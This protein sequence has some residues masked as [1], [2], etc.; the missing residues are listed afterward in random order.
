MTNLFLLHFPL[1]ASSYL[2]LH[3]ER[4]LAQLAALD[5][6][7][8]DPALE[9]LLYERTARINFPFFCLKKVQKSETW[10][11]YLSD[12]AQ[13]Q[14]AMRGIPASPPQ[15]QI[16]QKPSDPPAEPAPEPLLPDPPPP[17]PDGLM[18]EEE[19]VGEEGPPALAPFLL[20]RVRVEAAVV[21]LSPAADLASS[22]S[23][24]SF[25]RVCGGGESSIFDLLYGRRKRHQKCP[26]ANR[27]RKREDKPSIILEPLTCPGSS[28][29]LLVMTIGVKSST[30]EYLCL[31]PPP[32]PNILA[33][34]PPWL[35]ASAAQSSC[36]AG[37][38][39]ADMATEVL[40]TFAEEEEEEPT[41]PLSAVS[42]L[43]RLAWEEPGA[44]VGTTPPGGG[45]FF[46]KITYFSFFCLFHTFMLKL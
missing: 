24:S 42:V 45:K 23:S 11:T 10:C 4:V 1:S 37:M 46:N 35:S 13:K 39:R 14:G 38:E 12:P 29:I 7:R 3:G 6:G 21:K 27:K 30:D 33:A 43:R 5:V 9:A 2:G 15:W 41:W 28:P 8:L 32:T 34:A 20:A 36:S 16:L 18:G 31:P 26:T 17:V 44:G 40:F 25:F 22:S 19:E